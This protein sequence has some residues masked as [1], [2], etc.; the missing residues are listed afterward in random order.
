MNY[1]LRANQSHLACEEWMKDEGFGRV[2]FPSYS[3]DLNPI[4]NLWFTLKESVAKDAPSTPKRM[5]ASPK[6]NWEILTLPENLR[7]YFIT[8]LTRYQECIEKGGVKFSV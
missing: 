6:R 8:L 2:R 5:V 1:I 7:P 3:P 4:E